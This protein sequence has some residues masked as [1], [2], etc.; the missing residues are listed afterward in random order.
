MAVRYS[1]TCWSLS[2]R[3]ICDTM[4]SIKPLTPI[5]LNGLTAFSLI[6]A[7]LTA[8][9]W[10]RSYWRTDQLWFS[11]SKAS[12]LYSI[13]TPRAHLELW[14]REFQPYPHG[15]NGSRYSF[16]HSSHR[17]EQNYPLPR[18]FLGLS[19][20]PRAG[21]DPEGVTDT[22]LIVPISYLQVFFSLLPA[23][24]FYRRVRHH[25]PLPG[26]CPQC[27]YDLRATPN[28]CPECGTVTA[29]STAIP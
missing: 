16:S 3:V 24:H 21:P 27:G 11:G 10:V 22:G 9:I 18:A 29:I 1:P 6:L 20:S 23:I 28:Q 25:R 2:H 14:V 7:T 17:A 8:A 13:E 12:V 15:G 26:P 4:L 19:W 5:A